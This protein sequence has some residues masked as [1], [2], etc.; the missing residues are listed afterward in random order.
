M[1]EEIAFLLFR[2]PAILLSVKLV[3]RRRNGLAVIAVIQQKGGVGKSTITANL[4]GEFLKKGRTVAL[5][6]LDPQESLTIWANFGEGLLKGRVQTVSTED[7][8]HFKA[9][10]DA[11]KRGAD[12]VL[13][14]CPPGLPDTGLMAGLVA[15]IVLLPVTPSPLDV[16]ATKKALDLMR[17][18]QNQRRDRKPVIGLV[19]SRVIHTTVLGR[20]LKDTLKPM[21]E[22]ILPGISQRI[23]IAEAV[24]QGLTLREYAPTSEGVDEFKELA[25]SIERIVKL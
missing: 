7:P 24:L 8:K 22:A 11:A 13:L 5:L 15:D 18:A 12:R 1:P 25:T 10:I 17:E 20:D 16:V 21:G 4:A 6:D 9:I 23:A 19:P 14:D 3:F 2:K